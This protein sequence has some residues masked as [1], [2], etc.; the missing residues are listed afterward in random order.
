MNKTI[1]V[2]MLLTV[3]L[4]PASPAQTPAPLRSL[5]DTELAFAGFTAEH[6]IH[7]GFLAFMAEGSVVFRPGPI[8]A[9]GVYSAVKPSPRLLVWYPSFAWISAAGDLGY[10]TG[11][12][13]S[14]K[15]RGEKTPG[16]SGHFI[17]LWKRQADGSFKFALDAG[18]S[19]AAHAAKAPVYAPPEQPVNTL[20]IPANAAVRAEAELA[21]LEAQLAEAAAAKGYPAGIGPFLGSDARVYRAGEYPAVGLEKALDLARKY[22]A[23]WIQKP[24]RLTAASSGDLGFVYGLMERVPDG[25]RAAFLRIW[26]RAAD[27]RWRLALDLVDP[28][29]ES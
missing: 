9:R 17:T 14:F 2:L 24:A 23:R 3:I 13:E 20:P 7:D 1:L 8:D 26:R 28:F 21:S 5:I 11:P 25:A 10:T 19:H 12:W 22:D 29:P 16:A 27:G 6:G 18:V 15:A 4:G